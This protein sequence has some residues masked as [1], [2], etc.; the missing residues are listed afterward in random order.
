PQ[1]LAGARA[2]ERRGELSG[3]ADAGRR[4]RRRHLGRAP[5]SR[6]GGGGRPLLRPGWPLAAGDAGGIAPARRLWR[7]AAAARPLRGSDG[8]GSRRSGRGRAE[9]AALR[10]GRAGAVPRPDGPDA[11]DGPD[12]P[13]A[14]RGASAPVVRPAAPLVPRSARTG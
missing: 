10:R 4:G 14:A 8:G 13:G 1:G 7:R 2:A 11:P 12:D 3:T 9:I 5:R 6:T